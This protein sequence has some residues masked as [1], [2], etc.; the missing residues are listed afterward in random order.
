[1]VHQVA[2]VFR[3]LR[4][5]LRGEVAAPLVQQ[6]VEREVDAAFTLQHLAAHE[7]FPVGDGAVHLRRRVTL[8]ALQVERGFHCPIAPLVTRHTVD[9]VV[10]QRLVVLRRELIAQ[11]A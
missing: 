7:E 2:A 10:R 9:D 6:I 3:A 5:R 8:V 11:A 1:M 4:G